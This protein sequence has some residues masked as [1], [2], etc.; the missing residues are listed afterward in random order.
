MLF[1]FLGLTVI[2]A[3]VRSHRSGAEYDA[4][5]TLEI[6]GTLLE[7][8]WQNPPMRISVRSA[9]DAQNEPTTGDLEGS[10]LSVRRRTNAIPERL[11]GRGRL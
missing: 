3:A 9:G 1:T 8:R 7:I 4:R 10:S 6:E 2:A 5:R 11:K